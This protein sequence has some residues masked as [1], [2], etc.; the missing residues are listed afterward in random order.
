MNDASAHRAPC[1][2]TVYAW[3]YCYYPVNNDD[4][5]GVALGVYEYN[6][7]NDQFILRPGS[8]YLLRLDSRE[9]SFTCET[10]KLSPSQQFQ[11]YDGDRVG[12]CMRNN[13]Y[14]FLDILAQD[15]PDSFRVARW[16][17]SSGSCG[18]ND[19]RQS[20]EERESVSEH[21]LHLYVDISKL[22]CCSLCMHNYL[23][24]IIMLQVVCI[25]DIDECAVAEDNCHPT[26]ASCTDIVGGSG[27]FE[28]ACITGYSG[29][30]VTCT[31]MG[32]YTT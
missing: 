15:A 2:G 22:V 7:A 18:E 28:C 9:D 30:G 13:G 26:L 14:E 31:S 5:V 16:G 8:Y 11:I 32:M 20:N 29:D 24:R 27:S 12:A 19:M 21:I 1:D 17:D 25:A 4:N 6:S 3:H 10:V 23:E